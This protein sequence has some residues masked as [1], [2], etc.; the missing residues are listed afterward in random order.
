MPQKPKELNSATLAHELGLIAKRYSTSTDP[1]V[2]QALEVI[3]PIQKHLSL[4]RQYF[5]IVVEFFG[6]FE[7]FLAEKLSD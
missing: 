2:L 1:E 3:N 5:K 7:E 4:G 6:G